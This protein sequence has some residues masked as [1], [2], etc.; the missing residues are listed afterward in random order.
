MRPP[1]AAATMGPMPTRP[2]R[3]TRR[4]GL[5]VGIRVEAKPDGRQ[6]V[7]RGDDFVAVGGSQEGH[8][9]LRETVAEVSDEAKRRGRS[10]AAMGAEEF[11]EVVRRALERTGP[12][13]A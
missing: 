3:V 4:K 2:P 7:S 1:G 5:L 9:H 11:R 13:P 10:T 8:E 12:P 6:R